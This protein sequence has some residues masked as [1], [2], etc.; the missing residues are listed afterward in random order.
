MVV[1]AGR[2]PLVRA[3]LQVSLPTTSSVKGNIC[4]QKSQ[5]VSSEC[6]SIN[7][8]KLLFYQTILKITILYISCV[9]NSRI[10]WRFEVLVA[11]QNARV[12]DM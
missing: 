12:S 8:N 7:L 3:S 11:Q 1:G 10:L 2:G 5:I 9:L 6:K 4:S